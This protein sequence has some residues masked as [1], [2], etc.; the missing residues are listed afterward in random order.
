LT[1]HHLKYI[2]TRDV[3][4]KF[5]GPDSLGPSAKPLVGV[6]YS[7]MSLHIKPKT[8]KVSSYGCAKFMKQPCTLQCLP[9]NSGFDFL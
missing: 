9:T 4:H 8:L 2:R 7:W 3:Q 5:S 1:L 6:N